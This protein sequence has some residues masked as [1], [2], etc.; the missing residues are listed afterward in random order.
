[1]GCGLQT[2][3]C[4]EETARAVLERN[5]AVAVAEDAVRR[6]PRPANPQSIHRYAAPEPA[7]RSSRRCAQPSGV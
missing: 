5:F 3:I 2:N 7:R 1:M 6:Q 4:V